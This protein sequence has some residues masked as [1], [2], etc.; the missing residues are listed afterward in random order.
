[1][2]SF[3][4]QCLHHEIEASGSQPVFKCPTCARRVTIPVG[5]ASG[6]TQ[7]F[8]LGF[9]A[10]VAGY[11]SKLVSNGEMCCDECME[12]SVKESN[13][14]AEVFCCTCRKF[15]CKTCH[16]YH[17]RSRHL[18]KHNM[19]GLDQKG[20]KQLQS[21]MKPKECYCSQP[22][23]GDNKLIFYCETCKVLVCRDC[24]SVT[25]NGHGVTELSTVAK[26]QRNTM[27]DVLTKRN[28][29]VTM[30]T[31]VISKNTEMME[32]VKT[33]KE[34]CLVA[35]NQAIETLQQTLLERKKALLFELETVSLSSTTALTIEKEQ[36]E[37]MLE[38][39]NRCTELTSH[40][41]QTHTDHEVVA[42]GELVSTE[43]KATTK[44]IEAISFR[45]RN[46]SFDF[47]SDGLV[48]ELSNLG[49]IMDLSPSPSS[50]T[51]TSTSVAMVGT[52]FVAKVESK[53]PKGTGYPHGGLKVQAEMR[54]KDH[55]GAVVYGEVE[56]H[57]DGTYT[58]TLTPQIT[59]PHQ[60]LISM[61]GQH[62][63]NSPHDL[64]VMSKHDYSTLHK[65]QPVVYCRGHPLCV[66]IHDSGDIYVGSSASSIYV[67]DHTGQLKSTIAGYSG[68]GKGP[69]PGSINGQFSVP[70]GLCIKGDMLYIADND[71]HCI[72]KLTLVGR[73]P[74][75]VSAYQLPQVQSQ[76]IPKKKGL[77][78]GGLGTQCLQMGGVGME[79]FRASEFKAPLSGQVT[80][81]AVLNQQ[82]PLVGQAT[83]TAVLNQQQ[84]LL[85][86]ATTKAVLN[87]QQP[88]VGQATTKAVL[89][90]QQ[91]LVGQ[92]TTT[93][94]LNQQQLLVG[95]ATT[96]AVLNQQQP[97]LGQAT[98][99]AVL[100]QQQPLVG[101]A[102]TKA[103]LNQQQLLV[104]QATTTAFLNQQQPLVLGQATTKAVLNQQQPL[105]G[106][107]STTAIYNQQQRL[108]LGQ[109]TTTA[110]LNQQ[111]PLFGQ[112][113]TTAIYNHQQPL[114]LGQ[115]TTT[116]VLNQQ[117]PLV[118][119][120]ADKTAVLNQQQPL[121]GQATTTAVLNLQSFVS[122]P[123][124]ATAALIN[125][126]AV[127]VDEYNRVIASDDSTNMIHIF[128]HNGEIIKLIDGNVTGDNSF[129]H[130]VDL[131]LDPYG[132]IHVAAYGS[133]VIKVFTKEGIYVRIYGRDLKGPR[134]I[135]I[136]DE[137][138]CIVSESEGN[139]L[140]I[141][142]PRGNKIHT[143][144]MPELCRPC[145][146][147]LDP[148]DGSVYVASDTV[149][150]VLKYSK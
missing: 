74:Q 96:T 52:R 50:S 109:A 112:A 119:G 42:V 107:A 3:C 138:Y 99:K 128:S 115:A 114:V 141:F 80:T 41:L 117:Q 54:T 49:C 118:F 9:E 8:H 100:N 33:T 30:L 18:S 61:D 14:Y 130:P 24:T 110:V 142:D 97:L 16:D 123:A 48:R 81:K 66:A 103:V 111:Q 84:P 104:G 76:G 102:T 63:Q 137:G 71:N 145:G 29:L 17:K 106:Q 12:G 122:D 79:S 20:A 144:A 129:L 95:Q 86:Q 90:Q 116:A 39:I 125:A 10:E 126:T 13:G 146:L 25:H 35:I 27:E 136:D 15:L 7:N 59:G 34:N 147:A 72:Q 93:A 11:T 45:Y 78:T 75:P 56:D 139:C 58:I 131:A 21:T 148:K 46:I 64:Q 47:Q 37:K 140:S 91:L 87:Q 69:Q 113:S 149:D 55:N 65:V 57:R 67:F 6:L 43:L 133:N 92:A 85:G 98:T 82:Q 1:M 4:K 77:E 94:F 44:R 51:W 124:S 31:D 120:Q 70:T 105:F 28:R 89:N 143:V 26:M 60:L 134:G 135:A 40:I 62:V 22:N 121:V 150:I 132:N 32:E 68:L 53:T 73:N 83:T 101:Q 127:I 2:H 108:V 38:D 88:L 36:L 5:G 19:V 23:H